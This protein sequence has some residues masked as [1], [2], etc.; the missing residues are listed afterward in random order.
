MASVSSFS[1][2]CV[3][4]A[5]AFFA[6]G[7]F[8]SFTGTTFSAAGFLAADGFFV[9]F[10]AG[11]CSFATSGAASSDVTLTVFSSMASFT[12][13]GALST[14]FTGLTF[15]FSAFAGFLTAFF[16]SR[17]F[18]RHLSSRL[19]LRIWTFDG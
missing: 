5:G 3:F 11:T 15:G 1:S 16:L 19:R 4:F 2:E 17:M 12:L 7:A 14:F 8:F 6:T 18:L 9:T 10:F 13:A